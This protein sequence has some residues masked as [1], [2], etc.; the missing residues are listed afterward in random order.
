MAT[1]DTEVDLQA[2]R[3]SLDAAEAQ[4]AGSAKTLNATLSLAPDLTGLA[5]FEAQLKTV[6]GAFADTAEAGRSSFA[7]VSDAADR[8]SARLS[9]GLADSLTG[10]ETD[11][12]RTFSRLSRDIAAFFIQANVL[13][14]LLRGLTGGAG[15]AFG[16]GLAGFLA[17]GGPAEAGRPYVVGERGPELFVPRGSGQVVPSGGGTAPVVHIHVTTPDAASFNRS[18]T[19]IAAALRRSLGALR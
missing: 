5:A 6:D 7:Q 4:A 17:D 3:A 10:V 8:A 12:S 16:Q 14:P 19:Q 18:R 1:S 11:W 9:R 15:G 13:Q 2:L